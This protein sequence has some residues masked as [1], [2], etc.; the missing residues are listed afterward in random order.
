MSRRKPNKPKWPSPAVH[1]R[2]TAPLS[3][4]RRQLALDLAPPAAKPDPAAAAEP[5]QIDLVD[6][7]AGLPP[8]RQ[9]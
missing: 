8:R 1:L 3:R 7:L 6:Y 5:V 9:R 2:R 4:D